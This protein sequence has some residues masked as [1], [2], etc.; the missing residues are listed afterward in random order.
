MESI[1][2]DLEGAIKS[3]NSNL[4]TAMDKLAPLKRVIPKKK[5]P[6]WIG[7][8]LRL[9]IDKRDATHRRYKRTGRAGLFDEFFRL[10]NEVDERLDQERSSFLLQHLN[11]AMDNKKNIWKELRNLGLLPKRNV[12]ELHGFSPGELND[13]F[14]GI[15]VS[16]LE[17]ID[18]AMDIILSANEEGFSFKPVTLNKVVLAIS[19]FSS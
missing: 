17:D 2:A 11:D 16:S 4:H 15:S 3:L 12:K 14:A 18:D 10:S 8:Q 6:P 19:H 13:H 7:P 9:L 5:Y 1:E